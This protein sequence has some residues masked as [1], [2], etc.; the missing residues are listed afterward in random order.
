MSKVE[1]ETMFMKEKIYVVG[2]KFML[3]VAMLLIVMLFSKTATYAGTN[4]SQETAEMITVNTSYS[5]VM[6]SEYYWYKVKLT[7]SGY[8]YLDFNRLSE[9]GDKYGNVGWKISLYV[10]GQFIL[11]DKWISEANAQY[12]SPNY[13]YPNDT[14]VYVRIKD[15]G[16]GTKVPYKFSICNES[17]NYWESEENDSQNTAD[18]ITLNEYYYGNFSSSD[19]LDYFY[20]KL[21]KTGYAQISFGR[22]DLDGDTYG[23]T[24]WKMSVIVD[25]KIVLDRVSIS[26]ATAVN[27]YVSPKFGYKK[28][29]KI[30]IR[31]ENNGAGTAVDYKINVK[32]ISTSVWE[33]ESNNSK[34]KADTIKLDKKFYGVCM[35]SNDTDWYKYKVTK[36]GTLKFYAG[37]NS[38]DEDGWYDFKVY[39]NN[40]QV[41][42]ANNYN[43]VVKKMGSFKVKK[44]QTVYVKVTSNYNSTYS[45]KLNY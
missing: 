41:I 28:G 35:G 37:K 10:N 5:G 21:N 12:I 26:E 18:K 13:G 6:D 20:A 38:L 45:I 19:T 30:Y 32:N 42:S 2:K 29:Q 7:Q 39:V 1:K 34:S 15:D 17:S 25:G 11:E 44:G 22:R 36:D 43:E 40:K 16:A 23:N 33:T 9:D 24:G 31:V 27:G 3:G 14:V 4:N 8:F